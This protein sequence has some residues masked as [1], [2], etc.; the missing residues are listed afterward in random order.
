MVALPPPNVMLPKRPKILDISV[1][2][3]LGDIF[4][5]TVEG[6]DMRESLDDF[7]GPRRSGAILLAR[8]NS[9]QPFAAFMRSFGLL[10]KEGLRPTE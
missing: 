4:S 1:S 2:E 10:E 3:A 9:C 5:E 6:A 7:D 8:N